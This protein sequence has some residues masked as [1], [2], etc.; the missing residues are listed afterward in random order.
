M[1]TVKQFKDTSLKTTNFVE[2]KLALDTSNSFFLLAGAVDFHDNSSGY[3]AT[4]I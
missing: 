2:K 4:L 3:L 1:I